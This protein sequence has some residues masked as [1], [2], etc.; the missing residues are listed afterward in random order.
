MHFCKCTFL[1]WKHWL[2][3]LLLPAWCGSKACDLFDTLIVVVMV[4]CSLSSLIFQGTYRIFHVP[5]YSTQSMMD[6]AMILFF[7]QFFIVCF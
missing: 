6:I 4:P 1:H 5:F 7:V 3:H 2:V